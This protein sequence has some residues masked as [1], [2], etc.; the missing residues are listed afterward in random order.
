M[1]VE[2]IKLRIM[3]LEAQKAGIDGELKALKEAKCPA[4]NGSR[5]LYFDEPNPEIAGS[6]NTRYEPC[7]AC[8]E[9]GYALGAYPQY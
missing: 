4:C 7:Q 1:D 3:M 6:I 8:N 9:T 5:S 2:T